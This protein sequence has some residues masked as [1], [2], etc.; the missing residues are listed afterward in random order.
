MCNYI[1]IY[2]YSSVYMHICVYTCIHVYIHICIYISVYYNRDLNENGVRQAGAASR[3]VGR[4]RLSKHR[5]GFIAVSLFL[6]DA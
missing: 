5:S 2:M 6:I 4:G 1:Y 3:R